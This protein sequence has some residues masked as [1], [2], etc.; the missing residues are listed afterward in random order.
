M[1]LVFICFII[2]CFYPNAL[3]A[4]LDPGTGSLLLSSAIAIIASAIFF[5]KSIF[6]KVISLIN[7]TNQNSLTNLNNSNN[8]GGGGGNSSK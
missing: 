5:L 1:K 6:Y 4:Y 8:Y 2:I 3:F 7:S